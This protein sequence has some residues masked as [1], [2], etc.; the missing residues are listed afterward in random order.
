MGD[1]RCDRCEES[2]E[3]TTTLYREGRVWATLCLDCHEALAENVATGG[4][5]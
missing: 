2:D 1:D 3:E 4:A 5:A